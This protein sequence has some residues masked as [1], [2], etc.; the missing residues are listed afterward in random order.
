MTNNNK[1]LP[2]TENKNPFKADYQSFF[3]HIN[4]FTF[5]QC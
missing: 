5:H 3:L 4:S 2:L 1:N